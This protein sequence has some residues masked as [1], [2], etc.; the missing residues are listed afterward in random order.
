VGEIVVPFFRNLFAI[1]NQPTAWSFL[2]GRNAGSGYCED[3]KYP[4]RETVAFCVFGDLR[5]SAYA[6]GLGLGGPW[7]AQAWPKRRPREAQASSG[8]NVFVYN[9]N[10]KMAGGGGAQSAPIAGIARDRKKPDPHGR[11][12]NRQWNNGN[13]QE[14]RA[15]AGEGACGP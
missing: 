10:K 14:R 8:G 6:L 9:E 4:Q 7:V 1:I 11:L 5:P 15:F 13:I 2:T 12:I 3:W